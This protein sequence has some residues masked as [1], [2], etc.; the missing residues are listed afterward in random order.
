MS[1]G[2]CAASVAS[3]LPCQG[4]SSVGEI[5]ILPP[6]FRAGRVPG[7]QVCLEA[8]SV[9]GKTGSPSPVLEAVLAGRKMD[10]DRAQAIAQDIGKPDYSLAQYYQEPASPRCPS[11]GLWL[12]GL[13]AI[14]DWM[15]T[16]GE[17]DSIDIGHYKHECHGPVESR[18]G[19]T[20]KVADLAGAE[21]TPLCGCNKLTSQ[22]PMPVLK[23]FMKS[24]RYIQ[25]LADRTETEVMESYLKAQGNA[26]VVLEAFDKLSAED[27]E[28]TVT[29]GPSTVTGG[30]GHCAVTLD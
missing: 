15:R 26:K 21:P 12:Q 19:E 7:V 14:A 8:L 10:F 29:H 30:R 11:S 27:Q 22:L 6:E 25:Q 5:E 23:S 3:V 20:E 16:D 1:M 9:T 24:V 13:L 2:A 17:N 28:A 18:E 4:S